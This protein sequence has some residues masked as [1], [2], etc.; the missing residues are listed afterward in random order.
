MKVS[1]LGNINPSI[2]DGELECKVMWID[3]DKRSA[4]PQDNAKGKTVNENDGSSVKSP[5]SSV[6]RKKLQDKSQ[7]KKLETLFMRM[8]KKSRVNVGTT[9]QVVEQRE[10]LRINAVRPKDVKDVKDRDEGE[11]IYNSIL[12]KLI[13]D[14]LASEAAIG[15]VNEI[16]SQHPRLYCMFD[17]KSPVT[18]NDMAATEMTSSFRVEDNVDVD[19]SNTYLASKD[20]EKIPEERQPESMQV[21]QKQDVPVVVEEND[22]GSPGIQSAK[23][24]TNRFQ[25]GKATQNQERSKPPSVPKEDSRSKTVKVPDHVTPNDILDDEEKHELEGEERDEV[26]IDPPVSQERIQQVFTKDEFKTAAQSIYDEIFLS[27][28]KD[29]VRGS[30]NLNDKMIKSSNKHSTNNPKTQLMRLRSQVSGNIHQSNLSGRNVS[31][32]N[33]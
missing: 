18:V 21:S 33:N 15:L 3:S 4:G 29:S 9:D 23:D 7:Y 14:I 19:K 32:T 27:M 24:Q 10:A 28:V 2:Y 13:K 25:S 31:G 22:T 26:A 5:R 6:A 11:S 16:S 17:K 8:K 12:G 1:L 20:I 30:L